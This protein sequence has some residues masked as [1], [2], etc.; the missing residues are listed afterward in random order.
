MKPD[1]AKIEALN[2]AMHHLVMDYETDGT[3]CS[4]VW[5]PAKPEVKQSLLEL[6]VEQEW[7]DINE[8]EDGQI[9]LTHVGFAVCGAKWWHPEHGFMTYK[10][11]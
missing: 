6:G 5:V 4:E 1:K 10:F 2:A 3:T 9:D 11:E 7:I 8:T